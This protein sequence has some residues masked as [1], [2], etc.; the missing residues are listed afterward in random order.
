MATLDGS[1]RRVDLGHGLTLRAPGLRGQAQAHDVSA[2][3][4]TRAP[5]VD[6]SGRAMGLALARSEVRRIRVV[7]LD[8]SAVPAPG[9][10]AV[11]SPAT[12]GEGIVLEV[13]DL[14]PDVAQVV[15]AVDA[16]GVATWTFPVDAAGAPTATARG[17]AGT[18]RFV[19][20]AHPAAVT[21]PAGGRGLLGAVGRT[22]L[23]LLTIPVARQVVP[24]AALAAARAWERRARS[25]RVRTFDVPTRRDDAVPTLDADAWRSLARGRSLWFVHG[26]F[27]SASA[28]FAG[29]PDRALAELH[30]AYDGRVVAF[31]HHTLGVDPVEN[32]TVLAGLTPPGLTFEADVVAHS[33]GG[34]VARALAGAAGH[35]GP[36]RVRRVVHVGT[37]NHGTALADPQ[38]LTRLLDRVTTL[39][40]L[41]PSGPVDAVATALAVVLVAVKVVAAYGVPALPGLASMDP[42]G[43]FLAALDAGG[44]EAVHHAVAADFEPTDGVR[45]LVRHRVGDL[46]LDRVFAD[47][48]N[49]L[50]VPRD[51]VYQGQGSFVVPDSRRLLLG[52]DRGVDHGGY[53]GQA[54]VMAT[55][56]RWLTS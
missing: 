28:G 47:A 10:E 12:D 31:D 22:V 17:G 39:L 25:T 33:R 53:F 54:D 42:H 13:P 21:G 15:L 51:G 11:R 34:L 4:P 5:D 3:G 7:T 52:S 18:A 49:D 29:V 40:N 56:T 37:P 32:V 8:V 16:A 19:V 44:T 9:V 50:V 26:T 6:G 41:A 46:V 1:G 43:P 23:E 48:A 35:D 27:S 2:S 45:R 20:P 30:R 14:G 24:P 38:N 55:V 36:L